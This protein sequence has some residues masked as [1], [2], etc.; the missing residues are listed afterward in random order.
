[1]K[2][3]PKKPKARM[4]YHEKRARRAG[5]KR[6][7]GIDEAGRGPLAG[8]VVAASCIL[9]TTKFS[10]RIDDSKKLTPLAR[11]KAYKEILRKAHVGIG[12]VDEKIIDKINIYNATIMAMEKAVRSINKN[13]DYLLIDG[14]LKLNLPQKR[15]Y[16]SGGDSK[17]LSIAA[18]SIVA[19][20]SRDM[21]ME[22]YHFIYP[23]YEFTRHK[24]YGTKLHK[25]RLA[26][27]GPSPI[28]RFT[29]RPLKSLHMSLR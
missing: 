8:P 6:I 29:F 13:P 10:E 28:H 7:A 12:I 22:Y 5:Y 19:K 9:R 27:H 3:K 17:S 14:R 25:E 16:I 11:L 26:T 23:H 4:L 2:R 1:M 18:A 15:A 24:G 20:V 21:I